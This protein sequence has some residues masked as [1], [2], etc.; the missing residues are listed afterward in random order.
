[1]L[2]YKTGLFVSLELRTGV[3]QKSFRALIG[4]LQVFVEATDNVTR[5]ET[6]QKAP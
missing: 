5:V 2:Q 1:M 4:L 3:K 6:L